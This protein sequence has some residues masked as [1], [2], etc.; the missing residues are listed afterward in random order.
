MQCKHC[1]FLNGEDDHRCLRCGRRLRGTVIAAPPGYSGANALAAAALMQDAVQANDTREFPPI[2]AEAP[3][4][5][6]LFIHPSQKVIP[7][8]QLQRHATSRQ[9]VPPPPLEEPA[10]KR[11][12]AKRPAARKPAGPP[13]EQATL[14][15]IPGAPARARKL[16]TDVEAQVFCE[17]PVA[18]P[19]H[20]FIAA[21]IDAAIVLI[22]FGLLLG[23]M[24]ALGG[25][26][27]RGRTFWMALAGVLALVALFY[28][29]IW[30]IAGRETAGMR[31]TDLQLITFDG[32]PLD[33]RS[34]ALRFASAW[35]SFCSGGLGIVW[36]MADE[37]N[38]TWHD[39]ISKTFPTVREVP[40]TFVKR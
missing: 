11:T 2:T 18:T 16:K 6:P 17:Q 28:G 20:R 39:H 14:D 22:G 9:A 24:E 26:L 25:S 37:E 36:A 7:F 23:I 40:R 31:A 29:L 12:P 10:P 15:F 21:A 38:L 8:D 5:T 1:G 13:V 4:Q 35:L 30:A 19:M 32:F 3:A 33:A 27:G 34:R